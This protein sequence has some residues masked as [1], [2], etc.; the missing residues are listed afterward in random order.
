[1]PAKVIYKAGPFPDRRAQHAMEIARVR[2]V[3]ASA[4]RVAFG[5]VAV[6]FSIGALLSVST[7]FISANN[8]FVKFVYNVDKWF[9][10]PFSREGGVFSFTGENALQMNALMNWGLAAVV[11]SFIGALLYSVLRPRGLIGVRA[12]SVTKGKSQRHRGRHR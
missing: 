5:I 3:A 9:Q 7:S 2:H 1:M 8:P 4:T 10:G 6:M 12:Q 11:Y